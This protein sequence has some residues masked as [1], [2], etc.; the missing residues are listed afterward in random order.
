MM[1]LQKF[2]SSAGVC[3][4][5]QGEAMIRAG[6]VRVNGQAITTLGAKVD[7]RRDRVEVDGRRTTLPAD[8]TYVALNKPRGYVTSC[9]HPGE[10][11]V[12]DLVDLPERL[13]PVGRLDK[14]S[15]G[16]LILTNDG[17]LHHRLSHPSFDHE[18]EYDVTVA[19]PITDP[20][21]QRLAAG[22]PLLGSRTRPAEI[23]R[24]SGRRFRIVL[25]EG[26]NR[27]IRRMLRKV[28]HRAVRLH[29]RRMATVKLG[30]LAAG[31]W[32]HLSRKEVGD[33]LKVL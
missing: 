8:R 14:D 31:K 24:L 20:A 28:G 25:R 26:K 11:I 9:R 27:Q 12:L 4:R 10:M 13:F 2:L 18:K 21:L 22:M 5:R 7:P 29:R 32:R 23:R 6:R 16:L 15:S 33:L 17:R 30:R 3:S 1:R 19:K